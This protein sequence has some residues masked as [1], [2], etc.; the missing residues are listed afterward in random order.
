LALQQ[1]K[2]NESRRNGG[3]KERRR[4]S[5]V[6]IKRGTMNLDGI[7]ARFSAI[8]GG[9]CFDGRRKGKRRESEEREL[10]SALMGS[11]NIG[12]KGGEL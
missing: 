8:N 4:S 3:G 1:G 7:G 10:W 5:L 9:R 2:E 6:Y 12:S 11:V